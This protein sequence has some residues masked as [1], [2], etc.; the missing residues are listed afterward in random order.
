MTGSGLI[1]TMENFDPRLLMIY[2]AGPD[3]TSQVEKLSRNV[4]LDRFE[5]DR[6]TT[7]QIM[8]LIE[9]FRKE[10]SSASVSSPIPC[11]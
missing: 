3:M 5:L 7:G 6:L 10:N 9:H 1:L 2:P 4:G 8:M 11:L